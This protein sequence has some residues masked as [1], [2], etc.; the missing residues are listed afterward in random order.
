MD[1]KTFSYL[2]INERRAPV[3]YITKQSLEETDLKHFVEKFTPDLLVVG[4]DNLSAK[5]LVKY[6]RD[7]SQKWN[8]ECKNVWIKYGDMTASKIYAKME[9]YSIVSY[10]IYLTQHLG[11]RRNSQIILLSSK[12]LSALPV[13]NR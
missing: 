7:Q 10:D 3:E 11:L 6:L 2:L 13:S 8:D 5:S 12:R 4:A 9:V 1:H